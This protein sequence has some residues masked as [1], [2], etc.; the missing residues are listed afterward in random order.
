M[1]NVEDG[2]WAYLAGILDGEGSID[3]YKNRRRNKPDVEV[4]VWNTSREL[5]DWLEANFQGYVRK[6][7]PASV[8]GKLP[9]Y[10]WRV[11]R[12]QKVEQIL[13]GVAPY[14]IIKKENAKKVLAHLPSMK[15]RKESPA[16]EF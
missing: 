9:M 11:R 13:Q 4:C 5:M 8:K 14:L 15:S 10:G 12:R 6:R 16:F 2:K 7:T 1:I 3:L